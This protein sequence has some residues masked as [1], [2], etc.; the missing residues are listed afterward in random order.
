MTADLLE[1]LRA[2]DPARDV[3]GAPPLER[4]RTARRHRRGGLGARA[5]VLAGAAAALTLALPSTHRA[6]VVAQ[7]AAVLN[8]PDVL[9]MI[10]VTRQPGEPPSRRVETWRD[11]AGAGRFRV[12]SRDGRPGVAMPFGG[13]GLNDDPL[14]LLSHARE[15]APGVALLPDTTIGDR[16]VHVIRL[17][18][19]R[20][21]E[22]PVP[23]RT[24]YLDAK[25]FLPVRIQFGRTV[26]DVLKAEL[27]THQQAG[28]GE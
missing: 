14:S 10:T 18:P 4:V 25:T 8:G 6:D 21:G 5:A 23:V 13:G 12:L 24:Y 19:T 1:R 3:T 26:T 17:A 20:A 28:L 11:A 22:D 7:A 27:V 2:A 9:H 16:Q 15:G